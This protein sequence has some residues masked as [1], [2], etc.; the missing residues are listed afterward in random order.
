MEGEG[1]GLEDEGVGVGPEGEGEG[2]WV[3]GGVG[4]TTQW[5]RDRCESSAVPPRHAIARRR[6][7]KALRGGDAGLWGEE[8]VRGT[9][10]SGSRTARAPRTVR[11]IALELAGKGACRV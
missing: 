1:A 5:V 9:Q 10:S 2:V 11:A 3:G 8:G 4:G 6:Y 7:G